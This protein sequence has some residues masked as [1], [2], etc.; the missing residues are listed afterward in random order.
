[1]RRYGLR[2][3]VAILTFGLGVALSLALGLFRVQDT[4]ISY[5]WSG[6]TSCSKKFRLARPALAPLP[7][8]PPIDIEVSHPLR[9]V[10][11]GGPNSR[12]REL[13][14][15]ILLENRS[16]KTVSEYSLS[17]VRVSIADGKVDQTT[18]EW[19][20]DVMLQPGESRFINLPRDAEGL[21]LRVSKVT[22]QDGS[23]WTNSR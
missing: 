13:E 16:K 23:T 2:F 6:R 17:A 19:S 9:L 15:E 14:M 1:M 22:F 10:Y 12:G 20:S 4:K 5:G 21:V 18:F 11:F 8:V 3:L 7:A